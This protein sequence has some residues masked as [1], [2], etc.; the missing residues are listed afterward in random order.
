MKC[1]VLPCLVALTLPLSDMRQRQP[2]PQRRL[3]PGC[4]PHHSAPN[5]RRPLPIPF[6]PRCDFTPIYEWHM[7]E[8]EKKKAMSKEVRGWMRC[9]QAA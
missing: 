4:C 7:A 9:W 8:R 3:C 6:L 2:V 1:S 5:P